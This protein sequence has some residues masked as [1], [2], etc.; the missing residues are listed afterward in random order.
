MEP[1]GASGDW[2]RVALEGESA[3]EEPMWGALT[4]QLLDP[5]HSFLPELHFGCGKK[6]SVRS[7]VCRELSGE[8]SVT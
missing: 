4:H 2:E 1:N 6:E 3:V 5:V 8:G 7:S